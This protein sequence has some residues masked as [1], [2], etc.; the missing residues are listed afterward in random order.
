M[1][2]GK[3]TEM[4]RY[5]TVERLEHESERRQGYER[6]ADDRMDKM[7]LAHSRLRETVIGKDGH[8]GLS[9]RVAVMSV[10]VT[11]HERFLWMLAT[12]ACSTAVGVI[13]KTLS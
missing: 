4:S 1:G 8:N 10:T 3:V 6:R 13:V 7:E 2:D 12:L 5:V 9:S 11:R